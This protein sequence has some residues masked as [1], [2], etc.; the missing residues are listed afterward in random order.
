MPEARLVLKVPPEARIS[1]LEVRRAVKGM[2]SRSHL[3]AALVSATMWSLAI[4]YEAARKCAPKLAGVV[5]SWQLTGDSVHRAIH[6]GE[7]YFSPQ[8]E[9]YGHD[10]CA[11]YNTTMLK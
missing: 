10:V 8:T 5:Q 1:K 3:P 6:Q 11:F 4:V 2:L 7:M 9:G